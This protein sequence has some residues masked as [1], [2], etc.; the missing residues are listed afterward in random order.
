MPDRV[1]AA[2]DRLA[3]ALERFRAAYD[4]W[5]DGNGHGDR[6]KLLQAL[7]DAED[8]LDAARRVLDDVQRRPGN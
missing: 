5:L 3:E 4:A 6:E 2:I 7:A 8:R 1:L